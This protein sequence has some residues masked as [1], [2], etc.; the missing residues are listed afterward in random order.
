VPDYPL[1]LV[2]AD[3][4]LAKVLTALQTPPVA[5]VPVPDKVS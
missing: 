3:D 2:E 1:R 4:V 5:A